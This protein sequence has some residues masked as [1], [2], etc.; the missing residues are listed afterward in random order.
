MSRV[1]VSCAIGG[2]TDVR[3]ISVLVVVRMLAMGNASANIGFEPM[4]SCA[5][6]FDCIGLSP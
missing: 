6:T 2:V 3:A 5:C 4:T 1:I